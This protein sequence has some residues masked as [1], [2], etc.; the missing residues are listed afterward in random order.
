MKSQVVGML[1]REDVVTFLR[2]LHERG[3]SRSVAE[4]IVRMERD[5]GEIY[6]ELTPEFGVPLRYPH[7]LAALLELYLYGS[8][9][10][11]ICLPW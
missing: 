5:P 10:Y 11:I 1:G 9:T 4:I 8:H 2:N 7:S 6:R 3:A